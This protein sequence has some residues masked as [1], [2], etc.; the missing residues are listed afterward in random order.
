MAKY[1]NPKSDLVFKRIFGQEKDLLI[2]FLNAI[3]PLE[4]DT[5]I[6]DLDY[7]PTEEVPEI[8]DFKNTI[9][10]VKCRANNNSL[11]I[12]EMQVNWTDAFMQRVLFNAG[13]AYVRQLSEG[14]HYRLLLPVFAVSI[15]DYV[16]D[17]ETPEYYHH[18]K[19][20]NIKNSNETIEGLQFV[21]IELPKFN[22][23]TFT[24]KKMQA[25][26]L[27]FLQETGKED[28]LSEDFLKEKETAKA[29]KLAEIGTYSRAQLDHYDRYF[30]AV[31]TART[32]IVDAEERGKKI[33]VE[34]GK[35]GAL[36]SL[37]QNGVPESEAKRLLGME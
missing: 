36:K 37:I 34:E 4:G 9:V 33:G 28:P 19:I 23:S 3:L 8:P 29:V 27:R 25:L 24:Q 21:F 6:V 7:L 14:Q 26:W 18:Y 31:S 1:L 11:F 5:L 15:V 35:A 20:V 30:D 17:L 12:V 2:S 32:F 10:D 13:K 22:A 16:F